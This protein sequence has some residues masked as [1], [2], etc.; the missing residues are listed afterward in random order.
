MALQISA[1]DWSRPWFE[2][3]A[4]L[5]PLFTGT[6]DQIRAALTQRARDGTIGSGQNASL[7]FVAPDDAGAVPYELHIARSGRVPTR[8]NLHD[9]FNAAT[10]LTWP[11]LK[12]AL[13][14]RQ[15]LCLEAA[16]AVQDRRGGQRDAAT[17]LD[18]SGFILAVDPQAASAAE[19]HAALV[20]HD[21]CTLFNRWRPRWHHHW[22][23]WL[24]GHAVMEKLMHP[25]A[26]LTVRVL[27]VQVETRD[28]NHVLKVDGAAAAA[29]S[30]N[31]HW[32]SRAFAPMPVLGVP[33]WWP[34]NESADFYA[35]T[36]VFRPLRK[37]S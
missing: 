22:S 28:L 2:P 16:G 18:E 29:L 6:A 21:W 35:N 7:S 9:F 13:N 25:Y 31:P 5:Q 24:I 17:L 20:T 34:A 4:P 1:V 23:A 14:A 12:A 26:A 36:E 27:V 10:W 30:N 15:A 33:G 32:S 19:L 3:L 11:R 8:A 37:T